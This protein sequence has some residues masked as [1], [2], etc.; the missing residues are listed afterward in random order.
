V[1]APLLLLL[2]GLLLLVLA[3]LLRQCLHSPPHNTATSQGS[4]N[5][6]R[7]V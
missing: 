7:L 5:K 3:E 1:L 6:V 2:Q 4:W